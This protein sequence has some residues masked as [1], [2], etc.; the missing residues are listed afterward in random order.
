M[1][2]AC[3]MNLRR[4]TGFQATSCQILNPVCDTVKLQ[5]NRAEYSFHMNN[6]T[7]KLFCKNVPEIQ[8]FNQVYSLY[9]YNYE[10]NQ[11]YYWDG[12]WV[13]GPS[14]FV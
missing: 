8:R 14:T 2:N 4:G 7:Y 6:C 10:F 5:V 9:S 11:E 13:S 12:G 3:I 1:E